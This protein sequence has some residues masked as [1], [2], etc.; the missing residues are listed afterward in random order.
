MPKFEE[1]T[2]ACTSISMGLV[3]SIEADITSGSSVISLWKKY[4]TR[5]QD[6][7]KSHIRHFK[8]SDLISWSE[9]VFILRRILYEW[10]RSP[11]N[12]STTST[13]CSSTFGPAIIRPCNMTHYKYRNVITLCNAHEARQIPELWNCSERSRSRDGILSEWNPL[14]QY[15]EFFSMTVSMISHICPG[16]YIKVT[17]MIIKS[18]SGS[19]IWPADSSP[20]T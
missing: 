3:P 15:Q 11:S 1:V 18:V 14:L 2:N 9:S 20:L 6:F 4:F 17:E 8:N 13:M 16:Q 10:V 12:C 5:I 7:S 19:F